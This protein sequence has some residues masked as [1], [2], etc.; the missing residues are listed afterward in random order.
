[1]LRETGA[2]LLLFEGFAIKVYFLA[3]NS[4]YAEQII[5][6][7]FHILTA[8]E[9]GIHCVMQICLRVITGNGK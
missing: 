7:D 4:L 3:E 9:D 1:M 2:F 8:G 5:D 6:D